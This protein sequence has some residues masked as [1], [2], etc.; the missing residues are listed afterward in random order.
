MT[1]R[2]ES[3]RSPQKRVDTRAESPVGSDRWAAHEAV[4]DR[5]AG[6]NAHIPL[7]RAPYPVR[8]ATVHLEDDE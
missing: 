5:L 8:S 1:G 4:L 2:L 7:A 6:T 3:L